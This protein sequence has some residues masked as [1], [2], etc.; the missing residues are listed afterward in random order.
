MVQSYL[1]GCNMEHHGIPETSGDLARGAGVSQTTI[2]NLAAA[3][4][5]EFVV[6]SSGMRLFAPGQAPKVRQL[7]LDR[8]IARGRRPLPGEGRIG[9]EAA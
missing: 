3:G 9:G 8:A 2:G 5:L 7:I 1:W 4:L 6:T